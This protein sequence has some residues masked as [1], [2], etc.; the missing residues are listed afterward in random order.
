MCLP[1]PADISVC[2]C[3]FCHS[4]PKPPVISAMQNN[5]LRIL[6]KI[7]LFYEVNKLISVAI[8]ENMQIVEI[9]G[10]LSYDARA[11]VYVC[12]ELSSSSAAGFFVIRRYCA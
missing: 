8:T 12:N 2:I 3:L 11:R 1:V 6:N 10:K 5:L 4:Y 7:T 9:E